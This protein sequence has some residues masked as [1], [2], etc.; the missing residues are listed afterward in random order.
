MQDEA[1]Y[2]Y[3]YK[4]TYGNSMYYACSEKMSLNCNARGVYNKTQGGFIQ[5]MKFEHSHPPNKQQVLASITERT[6]IDAIVDATDGEPVKPNKIMSRILRS[7][8]KSGEPGAM[9]HVA[10]K[11]A[12]RGRYRR[13]L[14]KQED[15]FPEKLPKTWAD[16]QKDGFPVRLRTLPSGEPFLR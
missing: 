1:G 13:A 2:I 4:Y 11:E 9:L 7:L 16:L 5:R 10:K 6:I 8:E 12:L 14:K 15:F 3:S